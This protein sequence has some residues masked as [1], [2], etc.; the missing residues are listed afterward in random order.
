V[1][2]GAA[3]NVWT[4]AGAARVPP[5][6]TRGRVHGLSL[7]WMFVDVVWVLI[8]SLLYLS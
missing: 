2:I 1:V 4:I 3:A 8:L 5:A 6:L 7:Y